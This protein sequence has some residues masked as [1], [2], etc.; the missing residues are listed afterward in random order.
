M[1]FKI[2]PYHPSDLI[3]L[4]RI[5]LGTGNSG[6][7]AASLYR[8]PDL[9]GHYYA[10]PYA[11]LEPDLAFVL[12]HKGNP[13]GYV[14]GARDTAFFGL[15]CEREWFPPLRV[16]YPLPD[17][18]DIGVD[19]GMIRAIH[20]GHETTNRF[21]DFPAHLHIDILAVGRQ[22]GWGRRLMD[23]LLGQMRSM[24]VPGVH[25]GVAKNNRRA[26]GFY[27]HYG[28]KPLKEYQQAID[29]GMSL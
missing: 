28:F 9:L 12:T 22:K 13:C 25:L 1:F 4:Y 14:L 17:A 18:S 3:S 24:D 23:V 15:R 26:I 2:R 29:F 19:A 8:D 27:K 16:R 11:V 21:V 6:S 10:A 7:D 5:C 20:R